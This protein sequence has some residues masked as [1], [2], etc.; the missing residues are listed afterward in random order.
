M[1]I[2][3]VCQWARERRNADRDQDSDFGPDDYFEGAL[4][5]GHRGEEEVDEFGETMILVA[6]CLM[7]SVLLYVRGR[8]VVRIRIQRDQEGAGGNGDGQQ[9]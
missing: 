8:L 7:I 2:L 3:F 6:L 1:F 5:G 9:Q 4:R